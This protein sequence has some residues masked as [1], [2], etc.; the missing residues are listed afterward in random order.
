MQLLLETD[1][2]LLEQT[3]SQSGN[4]S[5]VRLAIL[6]KA[7]ITGTSTNTPTTVANVAPESIPKITMET[8]TDSSKKL[9]A[10]IIDAGDAM[11]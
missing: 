7:N 2:L 3:F 4:L 1:S 8:A 10:P 6:T 9:L 11:L 5:R